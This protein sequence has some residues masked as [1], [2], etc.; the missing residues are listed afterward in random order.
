MMEKTNQSIR[1]W[2]YHVP[3]NDNPLTAASSTA[4]SNLLAN[5]GAI[6]GMIDV[7]GWWQSSDNGGRDSI[8]SRPS[9]SF[10][11]SAA[12]V[13]DIAQ[14]PNFDLNIFS[15]AE[16]NNRTNCPYDIWVRYRKV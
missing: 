12:Y 6:I 13:C 14:M 10:G 7:G 8:G 9:S 2:Q 15:Y 16:G 5:L 3:N 1:T 11:M 4:V